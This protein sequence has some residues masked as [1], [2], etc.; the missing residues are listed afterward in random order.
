MASAAVN[1]GET[2]AA[3]TLEVVTAEVAAEPLAELDYVA[4]VD[5]R[6]LASVTTIAPGTRILM[7][8]QVGPARLIDNI[9]A[10]AGVI[11]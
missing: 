4:V 8:V 2:S 6:S 10:F 9:D 3:A 1:A 11:D 7:A 5:A